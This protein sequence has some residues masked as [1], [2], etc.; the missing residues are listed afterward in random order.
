MQP[1]VAALR[2]IGERHEGKTPSQVALRWLIQ[3]GSLPIPGDEER[4]SRHRNNAGSL[5]WSLSDR[6]NGGAGWGFGLIIP[7]FT[8]GVAS[9]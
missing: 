2:E 4:H 3:K 6:G 9:A 8:G 5:G 1:I 7:R